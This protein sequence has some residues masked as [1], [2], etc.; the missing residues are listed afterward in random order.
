MQP[1]YIVELDVM[2]ALG[3]SIEPEEVY[4][5]LVHHA[6]VWL[7][8][9]VEDV[10]PDLTS[11]GQAE[12]SAQVG[13]FQF[14][15]NV[16]WVTTQTERL[17]AVHCTMRQP[18]EDGHGAQFV[19]EFTLYQY[20]TAGAIRISLGRESL[21]GLM[22]P[23]SV[24]TLRRPGLLASTVRDSDL[25]LTYQGQV[26][27]GRYEWANRP[28]ASVLK[29]VIA[30]EKRLPIL[31]I[32]GGSE[33]AKSLGQIA[34]KQ[35]TGL[36]QV[37]L[38][39]RRTQSTLYDYLTSIAASIPKDGA[40]LVWPLLNSRHPEFWNLSE[41]GRIV[42]VLMKI[43]A[44][45]SVTARGTNRLR[46]RAAEESQR[47]RESSFQAEL[48][49]VSGRGDYSAESE[50]LLARVGELETDLTHWVEEAERLMEQNASLDGLRYQLE[51]WK[52]EAERAYAATTDSGAPTWSNAPELDADDLAKLARHLERT[53]DGAITFTPAAERSWSRC[54]YPHIEAMR[55][56]LLTLARAADA[57]RKAQCQTGMRMKDWLKTEYGLNYAADD[58]ALITKKLD[59]FEYEG[60]TYSRQQHLKLDD[61]VKPNEVGRVYF[62]IDSKEA[63]FIVD[64]VGL[65]LYGI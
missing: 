51:Y 52:A 35:L 43:V 32:D 31:L 18:I 37:L 12:L 4:N 63:R 59:R 56:A 40:R 19:C 2:T 55:E 9:D 17:R 41:S 1:L 27:D 64:H 44:S 33:N 65:K 60:E 7:S 26:V 34:A 57:W 49:K 30:T 10:E 11:S 50:I 22:S 28:H 14:V 6:T 15:R 25:R 24:E 8:R 53:S 62:A 58:G 3:S 21:D 39:D 23:V 5:R 16:R 13:Q 47:Q 42:T 45:V 54:G 38:V 48:A 36:A 29:Q 46:I 61:H 20:G